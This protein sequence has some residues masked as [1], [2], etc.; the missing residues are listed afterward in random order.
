VK[1]VGEKKK[2]YNKGWENVKS[3]IP[4]GDGEGRGTPPPTAAAGEG[5]EGGVGAGEVRCCCW[6]DTC[7]WCVLVTTEAESGGGGGALCWIGLNPVLVGGDGRASSC[8]P[9]ATR[10]C[11]TKPRLV[12]TFNRLKFEKNKNKQ[13]T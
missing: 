7:E 10:L 5:A 3:N 1:V 6:A 13:S 4:L 2:K 8:K 11:K 12:H 9:M